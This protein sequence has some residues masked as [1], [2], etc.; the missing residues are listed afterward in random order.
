MNGSIRAS[1]LLSTFCRQYFLYSKPVRGV[2]S[3]A[4]EF[5]GEYLLQIENVGFAIKI[6][7]YTTRLWTRRWDRLMF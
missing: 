2:L 3:W 6:L 5:V 1:V 4:R 7:L